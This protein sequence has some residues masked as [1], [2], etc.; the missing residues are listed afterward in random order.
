MICPQCETRVSDDSRYCPQCGQATALSETTQE[1]SVA[2]L[3]GAETPAAPSQA[4]TL[5]RATSHLATPTAT[6]AALAVDTEKLHTQLSQANLCR[7][8]GD[9][10]GAIDHCVVVLQAQPGNATAHSLLSDIYR[11]QGKLD[12]AIQWARLAIDLKPNPADI[13]KLKKLEVER[14]HLMRQGDSR[15]LGSGLSASMA[16]AADG[17]MVL[18]G[19]TKLMGV[20]PRKWLSVM[21]T[22]SMVFVGAVLLALLGMRYTRQNPPRPAASSYAYAASNPNSGSLLPSA[23]LPGRGTGYFPRPQADSGLAPD[24]RA[25]TVVTHTPLRSSAKLPLAPV[26]KVRPLPAPSQ[27]VSGVVAKTLAPPP[28]NDATELPDG[29]WIAS[30]QFVQAGVANVRIGLRLEESAAVTPQ[31]R[32][33]LVRNAFRAARRV[34]DNY[35]A[36][37]RI[38]LTAQASPSATVVFS[39]EVPRA[40][41]LSLNSDSD[42]AS[43]LEGAL[44]SAQWPV[45][46]SAQDT[47]APTPVGIPG[48]DSQR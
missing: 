20:A 28:P 13:A 30:V 32:E 45:M 3:T 17:G 9:W 7:M 23:T 2:A 46:A 12:D 47:P 27:P 35:E 8:R 10:S 36:V 29:M 11:D 43:Q 44:Q 26:V 14:T 34:F 15:L 24:L 21:T 40:A 39:A 4:L 33:S 19:T 5:V 42:P 16:L 18:N 6:A 38:V 22:A 37:Q 31:L 1:S 41:A 48:A 25:T